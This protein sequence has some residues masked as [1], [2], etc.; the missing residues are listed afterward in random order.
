M[1][2]KCYRPRLSRIDNVLMGLAHNADLAMALL[3]RFGKAAERQPTKN[4]PDL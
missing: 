3:C 2:L 4:G 1:T